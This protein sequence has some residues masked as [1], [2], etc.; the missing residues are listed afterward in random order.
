MMLTYPNML[1]VNEKQEI[2]EVGKVLSNIQNYYYK[3]GS[4]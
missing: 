1:V 2:V 3:L 4:K